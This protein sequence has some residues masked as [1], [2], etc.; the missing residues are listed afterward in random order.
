[1][2]PILYIHIYIYIYIYYLENYKATFFSLSIPLK[3][4][5]FEC[6]V[7]LYCDNDIY[8]ETTKF[9]SSMKNSFMLNIY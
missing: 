8:K 9:M 2:K 4:V 6:Y 3:I 1:M 5:K 7:F